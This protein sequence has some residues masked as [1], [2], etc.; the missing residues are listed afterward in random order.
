MKPAYQLTRH[1]IGSLKEIWSISWPLIL[2][3]LTMSIML[4]TDRLLLARYKT[5]ALNAG[6]SAG[7]AAYIFIVLPMSI[8]AI[9]EVFVGRFH[10]EN[11]RLAL[12]KPVW[13]M[14]WFAL[15]LAPV[16]ALIGIFFPELLFQHSPIKAMEEGYFKWLL[17]FSPFFC[18]SVAISGFFIGTGSVLTVTFATAVGNLINIVLDL[19]FIFGYGPIPEMGI[20]GAALATGIGEIFT[21]AI[22]MTLFLNSYNRANHG[23]RDSSFDLPLFLESLRIGTPVGLNITVQIAAY[24]GFLKIMA[25]AGQDD[26]TIAALVQSLYFLIFFIYEGLSKGVTTVCAN[27][28]G[29]KQAGFITN[30]LH[31]ALKLQSLFAASFFIIWLIFSKELV[32]LFMVGDTAK[33]LLASPEF[34]SQAIQGCFWML[35][36]FLFEGYTR[37]LAGHLTAAGDTAFLLYASILMNIFFFFAPIAAAVYLFDANARDAWALIALYSLLNFL[38]YSWR[39]RSGRW[40]AAESRLG[41]TG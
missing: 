38:L 34:L 16:F 12:G 27:L 37:V 29:G 8:A 23:T 20:F 21:L 10:G 14:L 11:K 4:F 35:G 18:A 9:S 5:E 19:L 15:L 39:Y 41:E 36:F 3:L 6:A 28:L 25:L 40:M 26:L 2:G 13:Q 33:E 31:A 30:V 24:F 32:A 17:F 1:P 22:L 7:T